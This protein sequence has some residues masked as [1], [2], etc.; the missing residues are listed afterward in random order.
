LVPDT[1]VGVRPAGRVS[2]TT[3]AWP[4]LD[5]LELGTDAV[6]VT[7]AEELMDSVPFPLSVLVMA[8]VGDVVRLAAVRKLIWWYSVEPPVDEAHPNARSSGRCV[9]AFSHDVGTPTGC[10]GR[11]P[12]NSCQ[13]VPGAP[14]TKGSVAN[15]Q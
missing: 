1:A 9:V 12:S 15:I 6:K 2:L 13:T 14:A 4:S 5:A 11:A 10:V 7:V 3:T 8:S